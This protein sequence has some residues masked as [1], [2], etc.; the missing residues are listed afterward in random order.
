MKEETQIPEELYYRNEKPL[1]E[2]FKEV[3]KIKEVVNTD[4]DF[5]FVGEKAS[6]KINLDGGCCSST[7]FDEIYELENLIGE[8][9]LEVLDYD[10]IEHKQ[11]TL[12]IPGD[13]SEH[14]EIYEMVVKTAKGNTH[15]IC[16]NASNGY[17]GGNIGSV[18]LTS[19]TNK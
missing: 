6:L 10:K 3:G 15:I 2:Y 5:T 1:S 9:V 8:E 12:M 13:K 17:Y 11:I 16:H 14:N 4:Y 7:Y 18:E 19:N